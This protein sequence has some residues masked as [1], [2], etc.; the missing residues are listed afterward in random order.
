MLKL[1]SIALSS[2][3]LLQ[4]LGLSARDMAQIDD[5]IEHANFHSEAYGDNVFVFIS[6]HYGEL[7]ASHERE[8]REEH[9]EHEQL[10]FH[11]S[12]ISAISAFVLT[13]QNEESQ[14]HFRAFRIFS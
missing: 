2:L 10:P 7:K 4:S 11:Q 3:I 6:K 8:H 13:S 9:G 1:I 5:F 12:Q 14:I